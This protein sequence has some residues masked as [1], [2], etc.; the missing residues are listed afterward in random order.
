[1]DTFGESR[2]PKIH[3]VRIYYL[4]RNSTI[5][6]LYPN[7]SCF[8]HVTRKHFSVTVSPRSVPIGLYALRD[9]RLAVDSRFIRCVGAPAGPIGPPQ[10]EAMR[11]CVPHAGGAF[12]AGVS[13]LCEGW[14]R[15]SMT[16]SD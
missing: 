9:E 16:N 3:R 14:R 12:N 10:R 7:I 13:L 6:F 5:F 11:Q 8:E 4:T 1:M 15:R 2:E